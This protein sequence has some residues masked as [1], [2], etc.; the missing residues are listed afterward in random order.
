MKHDTGIP[1]RLRQLRRERDMT[2]SDLAKLC[3]VTRTTV[4]NW[5]SGLRLPGLDS[6]TA[7]CRYFD[8]SPDYLYG[9]VDARNVVIAPPTF[10]FDLSK[11]N[12]D[13]QKLLYS[14]YEFLLSKEEF[15]E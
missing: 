4:T 9:R 11:L 13:G 8:I 14:I 6:V 5:E 10:R 1:A 7:I 12:Y 15:T 3:G 2:Q